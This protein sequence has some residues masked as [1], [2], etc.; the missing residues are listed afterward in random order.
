MKPLLSLCI[1][2]CNRADYLQRSLDSIVCQK[3]F[4][5]IEVIISDNDSNDNTRILCEEYSQK[6]SNIK[7][8]RNSSNIGSGN[9]PMAL[10]L[11]N[12][13]ARKV[14]NDSI[15]YKRNAIDKI[16]QLIEYYYQSRDLIYLLNRVPK[17]G[18]KECDK[19]IHCTSVDEML[20]IISYNITW[21]AS[22]LVWEEYCDKDCDSM[23]LYI[24]EEKSQLAQIP[25]LIDILQ[26]NSNIHIYSETIMS[27]Q[28]INRKNISYGLYQVFYSNYLNYMERYR[29]AG[30]IAP[31]TFEY[32]KRDLI[33]GFFPQWI[34]TLRHNAKGD[35]IIKAEN[36]GEL[37][38][39]SCSDEKYYV[40]L[41]IKIA[42]YE[43]LECILSIYSR[44]EDLTKM[45]GR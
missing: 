43:L 16:L 18:L 11:A 2:T 35:Y 24:S 28:H 37:I 21:I 7:Y 3:R 19:L 33:L 42:K 39:R 31:E 22:M 1:P 12:G 27:V 5:E 9:I 17:M 6:Y 4:D 45:N 29:E 40:L 38:K 14:S 41:C 15:I 30:L 36:L 10:M 8:Y 44:I 13:E 34:V 25:Y 20:K 32:L 23:K 26:H